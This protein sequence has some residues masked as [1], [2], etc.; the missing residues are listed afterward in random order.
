MLYRSSYGIDLVNCN[1]KIINQRLKLFW[2]VLSIPEYK[3]SIFKR[4]FKLS[5]DIAGFGIWGVRS[6]AHASAHA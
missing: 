1:R 5:Y 6:H 3:V 4:R 2:R